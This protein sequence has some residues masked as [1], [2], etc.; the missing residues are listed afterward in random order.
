MRHKIKVLTP[1]EGI[2]LAMKISAWICVLIPMLAMLSIV[3]D[4]A[5]KAQGSFSLDF[6]LQ[7]PQ[8]SGRE[9]GIFPILVSTFYIVTLALFL[10]FPSA[11]GCALL[12]SDY[13]EPSS[14][15]IKL[16]RN[17]VSVALDGLTAVPSIVFGIVGN[18]IF[19]RFFGFGY[20]VLAG[21]FT[22]AFMIWPYMTRAFEET[23]ASVPKDI[24]LQ[25][26]SLGIS[27]FTNFTKVILGRCLPGMGLG[28]VLA[29]SRA[30]AETSALLFTSGYSDR[31]P[32]SL[33]DSGRVISI[34]ILDLAMNVT[35][36]DQN[37]YT[38]AL[39]LVTFLL[40]LNLVFSGIF[41]LYKKHFG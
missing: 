27:P 16:V 40:A 13:R 33:F 17:S 28:I 38:S 12:I 10:V 11:L 22:L 6:L 25:S 31:I 4:I 37:A 34:H 39:T 1:R 18:T 36:G 41:Q 21:A 3:W 8:R 14:H 32:E 23:L 30:I 2:D 7:A 26:L 35:G 19:C 20:S 15:L 9:G 29:L 5:S 24:Y